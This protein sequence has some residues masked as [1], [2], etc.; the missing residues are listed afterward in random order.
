MAYTERYVTTSGSALNGGTNDTSDAWD[1][2]TGINNCGPAIRLNIKAGTYTTNSF[3]FTSA[4]TPTTAQQ[5]YIRGYSTTP[6]DGYLGRDSDHKIITTNMPTIAMNSG[7]NININKSFITFENIKITGNTNNQVLGVT[8]YSI[9]LLNCVIHNTNGGNNSNAYCLYSAA[10]CVNSDFYIAGS[11][12]Y[13]CVYAESNAAFVGCY[14][15]GTGLANS[16]GVGYNSNIDIIDCV[17]AN[18]DIGIQRNYTGTNFTKEIFVSNTLYDIGSKG[19]ECLNAASTATTATLF[20][21]NHVTDSG[22]FVHNTSA[23]AMVLY[24][25]RTRDNTNVNANMGESI[26]V[27]GVTTDNGAASSDYIDADAGKYFLRPTAVGRAA[28]YTKNRDIGGV[29]SPSASNSVFVG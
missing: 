22:K 29:P 10:Y 4:G 11:A 9:F 21:N 2:A 25:N 13:G 6:G 17:I 15:L 27:Y 7:Q 8:V 20:V 1:L 19:Y 5:C 28:G 26:D 24:H 12:H 23:N 14:F 3:N 16:R 18:V